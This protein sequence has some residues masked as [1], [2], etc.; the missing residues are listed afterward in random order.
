MKAGELMVGDYIMF[1]G[2]PYIIEEISGKGWIHILH[3]N[4]KARVAL[5]SDY[6]LDFIVGVPLTT[7]I[8]E[9]NEFEIINEDVYKIAGD[10]FILTYEPFYSLCNSFDIGYG[11]EY[12]YITTIKYV[13]E[14]Q[15]ILK[16]VGV[17]KEIE[18]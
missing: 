8:L 12:N 11:N 17:K 10:L 1:D 15:N 9:K 16:I 13:H 5:S 18:L 14:L 4:N 7:E 6:I 3:I 2:S